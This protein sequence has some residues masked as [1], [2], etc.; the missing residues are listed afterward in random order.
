MPISGYRSCRQCQGPA[1]H[2]PLFLAIFADADD[3]AAGRDYRQA[4]N[5]FKMPRGRNRLC[6]LSFMA[7]ICASMMRCLLELFLIPA[8]AV[9]PPRRAFD[10]GPRDG[11][12]RQHSPGAVIIEDITT[13]MPA[14][15]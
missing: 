10:A 14:S 9:L 1:I 11:F 3:G 4:M 12:Y 13:E 6:R 7:R 15:I 5:L 8:G 2:S